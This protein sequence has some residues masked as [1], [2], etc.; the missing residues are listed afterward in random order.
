[1]QTLLHNLYQIVNV[2]QH[3][4]LYIVTSDGFWETIM[5]TVN[6]LPRKCMWLLN[7]SVHVFRSG[8]STAKHV[9]FL[10]TC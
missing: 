6:K 2:C 1:M 8:Q 5:S 3:H 9:A 7:L 10:T 4:I